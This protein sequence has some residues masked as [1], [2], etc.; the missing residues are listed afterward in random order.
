MI[1]KEVGRAHHGVMVQWLVTWPLSFLS[2][3]IHPVFNP[4][5]YHFFFRLSNHFSLS[6]ILISFHLGVIIIWIAHYLLLD[7]RAPRQ[8]GSTAF[9]TLLPLFLLLLSLT[10]RPAALVTAILHRCLHLSSRVCCQAP[11]C[12]ASCGNH[13][14]QCDLLY[15][16]DVTRDGCFPLDSYSSLESS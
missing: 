13:I 6:L 10:A 12:L 11:S 15:A 5:N 3:A 7:R 4:T 8:V 16:G 1:E 14:D 2:C 9:S